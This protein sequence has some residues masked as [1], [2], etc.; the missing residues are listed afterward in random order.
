VP[1]DQRSGYLKWVRCC[2]DFCRKYSHSP[3]L[4]TSLSPFLTKLASKAT[5]IY[6]QTVP[7]VALKEAKSPL[8]CL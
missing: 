4:P 6:R 7:D 8:D 1:A 5:M 3:A 2:F